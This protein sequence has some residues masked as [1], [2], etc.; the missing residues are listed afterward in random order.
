[1]SVLELLKSAV[2][3]EDILKYIDDTQDSLRR[4]KPLMMI[5]YT[6][7]WY[8]HIGSGV[9]GLIAEKF[10][11]KDDFSFI[12]ASVYYMATFAFVESV[13]WYHGISY[14]LKTASTL[15]DGYILELDELRDKL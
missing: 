6:S 14:S 10:S 7:Q 3:R 4:L 15:F 13:V 2:P 12:R 8:L 11:K 1:M 5:P 9:V